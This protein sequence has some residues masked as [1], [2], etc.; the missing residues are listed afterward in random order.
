MKLGNDIELENSFTFDNPK[1]VQKFE[2]H[3]RQSVPCYDIFHSLISKLSK[4]FVKD[5]CTIVDVGCSVG[6]LIK[7]I[8]YNIGNDSIQYYGIDCSKDMIDKANNDNYSDNVS[9]IH[10]RIEDIDFKN[11]KFNGLSVVIS[12]LCLQFMSIEDRATTIKNIYNALPMGGAFI[13]VEKVLDDNCEIS[14]IYNRQYHQ[15]KLENDFT[16]EEVLNKEKSLIGFMRPIPLSDNMKM[17]HDTGFAKTSIFF[18]YL[19]FVGILGVK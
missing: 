18:K 15:Y 12:M 2:E 5:N 13:L 6:N 14:D 4:Y 17:L 9:F 3:V 1:V 7:L 11:E 19:G 8:N 16:P 10:S